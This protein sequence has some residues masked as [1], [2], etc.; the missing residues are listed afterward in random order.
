LKKDIGD[1]QLNGFCVSGK[2]LMFLKAHFI[3]LFLIYGELL[4]LDVF[5]MNKIMRRLQQL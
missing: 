2:K 3:W 5:L 4:N 1:V